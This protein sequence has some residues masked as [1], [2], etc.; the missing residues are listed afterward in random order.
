M[1][2]TRKP[3][4]TQQYKPGQQVQQAQQQLQQTA[5]PGSYTSKYGPQ[6]DSILQQITNPKEFKYSFDGDELFKYYADLYTQKGKQ[7][8]QDAM[9][10]AAQLTGGYGNSY[11]QQVGQQT[12]DQYLLNLYDKGM[13]LRDRAYQQH[14][15]QLADQ[16]NQ[17]NVLAGQDATD[18]GRY[19]DTVGDWQAD[20]DYLTGRYDTERNYDYNQ[21]RDLVGDWQADRDYAAGRYDTERNFDYN[22]YTDAANRAEQQ[23]QFD[24]QLA[25]NIRQF[26]ASLDW[27]KMSAQQK[28]AAEYAMSILQMGQMPSE[29]LLRQAGLS[30]EDAAKLMAQI[31]KG[32]GGSGIGTSFVADAMGNLYKADAQGQPIKGKDGEYIR[33]AW[34]DMNVKKSGQA[35]GDDVT[36]Q[37]QKNQ[38]QNQTIT[39]RTTQQP[40]QQSTKKKGGKG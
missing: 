14:Q 1:A 7:A 29:E 33:V 27:D 5:Q 22:A 9:G 38:L 20:R 13:E 40:E 30:A 19:R 36:Q 6:L 35:T 17:Y 3:E 37:Q 10:Q 23:Y 31:S 18:Y 12:Y 32:G 4:A 28:Y 11:G 8:S 39:K 25:E 34:E 24:A 26:D 15:D 21:Y 16:Y 2:V